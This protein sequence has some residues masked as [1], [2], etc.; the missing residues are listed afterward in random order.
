MQIK[1]SCLKG[2]VNR[3]AR[4]PIGFDFDEIGLYLSEY[5]LRMTIQLF[6]Q[7]KN[8][9]IDDAVHIR[10]QGFDLGVL[11]GFRHV[12]EASGPDDARGGGCS[13]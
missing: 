13:R 2:F 9:R 3:P 8:H 11:S 12:R 6:F 1:L 4:A 10:S 5:H 7:V